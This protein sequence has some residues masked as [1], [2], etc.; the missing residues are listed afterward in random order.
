M[1]I[2]SFKKSEIRSLRCLE[3]KKREKC[4]SLNN[5]AK[6]LKQFLDSNKQLIFLPIDKSKDLAL[7]DIVD[8]SFKLNSILY[9]I[10]LL[11][12]QTIRSKVTY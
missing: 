5:Y 8:Y 1:K 11:N 9:R 2:D 10:N 3:L 4:I 7:R 6:D 12:Y